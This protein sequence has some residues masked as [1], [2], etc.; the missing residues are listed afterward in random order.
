M[1]NNTII[2]LH[3]KSWIS[4]LLQPNQR[5]NASHLNVSCSESEKSENSDQDE[6]IRL[7][8]PNV[9]EFEFATIEKNDIVQLSAV[10]DVNTLWIRNTKHDEKYCDLMMK[11][12]FDVDDPVNE[13]EDN[14]VVLVKYDGDY[15][16]GIVVDKKSLNIQ[17][18]DIGAK[19][20]ADIGK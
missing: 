10:E 8:A 15:S 19:F 3:W 1:Y 5:Q 7:F 2:F 18:M 9:H 14:T 6:L 20:H 16:R 17:L 12:N 13:L 4:A 11:I